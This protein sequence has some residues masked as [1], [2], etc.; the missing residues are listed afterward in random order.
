M[1]KNIELPQE[2]C[3]ASVSELKEQVQSL[4]SGRRKNLELDMSPVE[5]VDT[6]GLQLLVSIQN[7]CQSKGGTL[8]LKNV[9]KHVQET[10]EFLG[11][12]ILLAGGA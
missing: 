9:P 5:R 3:A 2:L 10:A 12:S 1:S 7:S 8:T 4:L 6:L 11:L